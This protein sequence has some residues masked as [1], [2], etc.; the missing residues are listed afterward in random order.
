MLPLRP[1]LVI[2]SSALAAYFQFLA[3]IRP[4]KLQ[5]HLKR[6][7]EQSWNISNIVQQNVN[8]LQAKG[9]LIVIAQLPELCFPTLWFLLFN[10]MNHVR[11]RNDSYFQPNDSCSSVRGFMNFHDLQELNNFDKLTL[12]C[13]ALQPTLWWS[14]QLF[15]ALSL[16]VSWRIDVSMYLCSF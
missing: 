4:K 5:R 6:I 7:W 15:Y 10:K 3:W 1:K 12:M 14:L 13:G 2:L 8:V 16:G 9:L 11:Q